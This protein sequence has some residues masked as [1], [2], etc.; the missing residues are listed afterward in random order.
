MQLNSS[1]IINENSNVVEQQA[2]NILDRLQIASISGLL[3][4]LNIYDTNQS[5]RN[6]QYDKLMNQLQSDLELQ[7]I[8]TK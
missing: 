4:I 6:D 1:T 2:F 3:T 8:E 5:L 7:E